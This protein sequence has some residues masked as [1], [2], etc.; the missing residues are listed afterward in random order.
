MKVRLY[1]R[2]QNVNGMPFTLLTH[3]KVTSPD[4][5]YLAF[6][7]ITPELLEFIRNLEFEVPDVLLTWKG[8]KCS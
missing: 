1:H 5:R 6:A 2:R 3:C 8:K 7:K 4:G